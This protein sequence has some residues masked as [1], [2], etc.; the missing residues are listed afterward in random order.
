MTGNLYWIVYTGAWFFRSYNIPGTLWLWV[1]LHCGGRLRSTAFHHVGGL[2]PQWKKYS[3]LT[4]TMSRILSFAH[5][6]EGHANKVFQLH[7]LRRCPKSSTKGGTHDNLSDISK[8]SITNNVHAARTFCRLCYRSG[9][10]HIRRTLGRGYCSDTASH[11][12]FDVQQP[13]G[14][15]YRVSEVCFDSVE[16]LLDHASSHVVLRLQML[17][18]RAT[19][20]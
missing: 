11:V 7:K 9:R 1:C 6:Q 10:N 18:H 16:D 12:V 20:V 14:L 4:L 15:Q 17:Q 19:S 2:H 13:E 5:A 8:V 3:M